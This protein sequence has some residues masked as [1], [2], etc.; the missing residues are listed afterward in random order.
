[1]GLSRFTCQPLPHSTGIMAEDSSYLDRLQQ[2]VTSKSATQL[3]LRRKVRHEMNRTREELDR[4]RRRLDPKV[5]Q[6][7]R[8]AIARFDRLDKAFGKAIEASQTEKMWY[9][10]CLINIVLIGMIAAHTPQYLHIMYTAE[11]LFLLPI[12]FWTYYRQKWHFFLA[13]LCYYVNVLLLAYLWVWPQWSTLWISVFA[14]SFGSLAAS[15]ILWRNSLVLQSVDKTTSSF[16]HLMPPLVV[17][18][19]NFRLDPDFKTNR[20]PGAYHTD[21]WNT[22]KGIVITTAAYFVWQFLYHYFITVKRADEIK[23]GT[24]TSFEFMRKRYGKSKLGKFVNSLPGPLPTVAFTLIQFTFQMVTMLPCPLYYIHEWFSVLL[25][26]VIFGVASFNGASYYVEVYGQ[27]FHKQVKELQAELNKLTVE[28]ELEFNARPTEN[29]YRSDI[30]RSETSHPDSH[31]DA[32]SDFKTLE[33]S[34]QGNNEFQN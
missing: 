32:E 24:V 1:M 26:C 25:L 6:F 5:E 13:D 34:C 28:D 31:S 3:H 12:R 17:H 9:T 7:R 33:V 21:T 22:A 11:L 10:V 4:V 8:R 30:E 14:F 15:V 20:F 19:I 23:N 2:L 29:E 27:R 18:C 16:I